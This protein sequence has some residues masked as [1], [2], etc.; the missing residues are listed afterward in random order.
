MVMVMQWFLIRLISY[1]FTFKCWGPTAVVLVFLIVA[2]LFLLD[3]LFIILSSIS[4]WTSLFAIMTL[5]NLL[6]SWYCSSWTFY[7]SG[8]VVN[9]GLKMDWKNIPKTLVQMNYGLLKLFVIFFCQELWFHLWFFC[10]SKELKW[11]F[12]LLL[13]F[14]STLQ[15][16]S[17]LWAVIWFCFQVHTEDYEQRINYRWP[18]LVLIFLIEIGI[19]CYCCFLFCKY[20]RKENGSFPFQFESDQLE[21]LF[22]SLTL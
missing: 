21:L 20:V 7:L 5:F 19:L 6:S 13:I 10:Y 8:V 11:F 9:W 3:G 12:F 16:N 15:N 2:T 17:T 14:S 18:T 4:L 22:T 1:S